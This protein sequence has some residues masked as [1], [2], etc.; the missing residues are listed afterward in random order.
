MLPPASLQHPKTLLLQYVETVLI[1]GNRMGS[2]SV[3]LLVVVGL[4]LHSREEK[5]T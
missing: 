3:F 1:L 5:N 4:L 2:N